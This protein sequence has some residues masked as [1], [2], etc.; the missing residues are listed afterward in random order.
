MSDLDVRRTTASA[1]H[2]LQRLAADTLVPCDT[3]ERQPPGRRPKANVAIDCGWGRLIF[4]H[5]FDGPER[6]AE[7]LR[8]ET[9]G[10]RDIAFYIKDPQVL[11]SLAPQEL[12]LDP[13]HTFRLWLADYRPARRRNQAFTIAPVRSREEIDQLNRIYAIHGMVRVDPDFLL[14]HLRARSY[15]YLVAK[16]RATGDVVGVVMGADHVHC[17]GDPEGGSSLWS[18]AVDPQNAPPGIGEA[19]VRRLVERYA[20]R[21]RQFLDLSVMHDNGPA[22]A[23]YEKLGFR[24]VPVFTVKRRNAVNEKLFS[25]PAPEDEGYNPYA[26]LI[27]DEAR[28]R[29]IMVEP[30][31]PEA[32]YFKLS[33][34][35][36]S[37]TCR[38]SLSELTSAV[39]MSRCD[40]KQVTRRLMERAG[41]RVPAQA[42]AGT[43]EENAAFLERWG[44]IVVKP[45]RGEQGAG[46]AVDLSTTEEV[47][48]AVEAARRVDST[49]VMEEFVQGHDLRIIVIGDEVVAAAMRKPAEVVGDGRATVRE[50]IDRHSRR[51]AKATGGESH[52][53]LDGETERCVAAYGYGLDD[54]PAEGEALVVRKTAN[55]HTGG[56]IHDVTD[57]LHPELARAALAA[58]AAVEIPVVGLDFMIEA[59]DRRAYAIIEANE[60]PGLAN[61]EPQPTAAKFVDLLFPQTVARPPAEIVAA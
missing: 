60:R 6:L 55:L 11:L 29:G 33:F 42:I 19:L 10:H 37:I 20:G 5:T 38:E 7:V 43:A 49:V 34:G 30:V 18:L 8:A 59:P 40:D 45:A 4:G 21:G 9:P 25:T 2:R 48:A 56:T 12:F 57:E 23:L 16:T 27:I 58:A 36:R 47:E 50:L 52:I 54:V 32:G 61:H 44:R 13:S 1:R 26:R 51:R 35:G 53:P 24:R 41:L 17:F 39:A 3:G 46:V 22:V 31:D 14:N 15:S 28:R